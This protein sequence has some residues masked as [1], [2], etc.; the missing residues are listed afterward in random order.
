MCVVKTP[1]SHF[2]MLFGWGCKDLLRE[3]LLPIVKFARLQAYLENT[4]VWRRK[5]QE[6]DSL[7]P[8]KIH[9]TA[10]R[11]LPL[12][13][14]YSEPLKEDAELQT[15]LHQ[16]PNGCVLP[17]R[18]EFLFMSFS[19]AVSLSNSVWWTSRYS[20]QRQHKTS[21]WTHRENESGVVTHFFLL[22]KGWKAELC[23][24]VGDQA[25]DFPFLHT[26]VAAPDPAWLIKNGKTE[27]PEMNQ[28]A[29]N[30]SP[31]DWVSPGCELTD[32]Y[33]VKCN[34]DCSC[35]STC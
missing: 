6:E 3:Y 12:T 20:L 17:T 31:M 9:I 5:H 24:A 11:A 34:L 23:P 7:F 13:S 35:F 2:L 18:R 22:Q 10:Q 4:R 25:L 21:L 8:S 14:A 33:L 16:A 32:F 29:G 30:S 26:L 19:W 15:P 28:G 27:G 1:T